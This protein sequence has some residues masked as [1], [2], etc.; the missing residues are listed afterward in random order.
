MLLL[1]EEAVKLKF[2]QMKQCSA[3]KIVQVNN[4]YINM[5]VFV[6]NKY[7][8]VW[9]VLSICIVLI[10]KLSCFRSIETEYFI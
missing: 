6:N 10:S 5:I 9:I 1:S 8:N 2:Y 3:D 7:M 4:H